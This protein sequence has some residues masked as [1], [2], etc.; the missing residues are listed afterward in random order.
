MNRRILMAA[1]VLLMATACDTQYNPDQNRSPVQPSQTPTPKPTPAPVPAGIERTF[2]GTVREVNGGPIAGV[3]VF[4]TGT[5]IRTDTAGDGTF[6]LTTTAQTLVFQKPDYRST[7]WRADGDEVAM[8]TREIRMQ[9]TFILSST[10]PIAS[11]ITA[12]DL[13]YTSDLENSFWMDGTDGLR[14]DCRPCKEI[15]LAGSL[16]AGAV[17]RL[18]WSGPQPL[19][20]WAGDLYSGARDHQEGGADLTELVMPLT[21]RSN[22]M[23]VGLGKRNG[24]WQT[25]NGAVTFTLTV[26]SP[27][28]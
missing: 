20:L 27:A 2:S 10:S 25:L 12:D 18:K 26:E 14:Y 6:S 7:S 1:T 22:T 13:E 9:P 19:D 21:S 5:Q 8:L 3:K 15:G 24:E 17:L 11:E 16:G 28:P 23:L 4:G